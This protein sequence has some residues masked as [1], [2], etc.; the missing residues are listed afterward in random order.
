MVLGWNWKAAL[1]SAAIR[2]GIF[3]FTTL[4]AGA[5]H[6]LTATLAEAVFA[7]V[8]AGL[9]GAVTQRLRNATP[10]W[11]TGVIVSAGM[12]CIL[13]LL[14][15][16]LHLALGTPHLKA[17]MMVTFIYAALA[18]LFNWFAMRHGTLLTA[19]EGRPLWRDVVGMPKMVAEF[20]IALPMAAWRRVNE[21][22]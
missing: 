20:L 12:P 16:W 10:V 17:G 5:R 7:A 11:L 6:A 18:M 13:Q 2:G 21:K 22:S 1:L 9:M 15:Y 19:G 4:K 3:F 8:V 14:Q